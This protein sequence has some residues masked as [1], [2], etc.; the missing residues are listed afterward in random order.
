MR[1][2][3]QSW[4]SPAFCAFMP[5]INAHNEQVAAAAR[6]AGH[7]EP[8]EVGPGDDLCRPRHACARSA[9]RGYHRHSR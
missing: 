4:G 3:S 1:D 2:T 5:I 6:Q 8:L 9:Y 7:V